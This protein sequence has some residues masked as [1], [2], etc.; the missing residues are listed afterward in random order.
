MS[1]VIEVNGVQLVRGGNRLFDCMLLGTQQPKHGVPVRVVQNGKLLATFCIEVHQFEGDDTR[2][3]MVA[4]T[5]S[6]SPRWLN[7]NTMRAFI[8]MM[9]EWFGVTTYIGWCM[10]DNPVLKMWERFGFQKYAEY[11]DKTWVLCGAHTIAEKWR[12]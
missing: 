5:H 10:N 4:L 2:Y 12:L 3:G 11:Q 9:S 8:I 1:D 6:T 7:K